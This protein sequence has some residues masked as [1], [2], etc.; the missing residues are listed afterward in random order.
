MST[1]MNIEEAKAYLQKASGGSSLYDHLSEVLLKIL[2]EKPEDSCAAF[3]H[4]SEAVKQARFTTVGSEDPDSQGSIH[5][6]AAQE[7]WCD[8]AL[9]LLKP[10]SEED[11]GP[12][13][14]GVSDLLD[15]SN[16]FEWAGIGFSR[17]ETFRLA[18]ALQNLATS[19][20]T[21][22]MRLWGKILGKDVDFYI[23]EGQCPEA[24]ESE[25]AAAYEGAE[26]CN[27]L[28]YWAMKDTGEYV[29]EK[30]PAVSRAQIQSA[31]TL[32]R[33][34]GGDLDA[35]VA[36]NPPFPGTERNFLRAQIARITASTAICP[37]GFFSVSD[38]G[39]VTVAE[40][41]EPKSA[42]ELVEPAS[43]V[44]LSKELNAIYGRSTPMPARE[45]EDG[46]MLPWE[47]EEFVEVLRVLTEDE[48][49]SWKCYNAPA[50]LATNTGEVAVLKSLV[51]PGAAAV[52]LGK[53]FLNVYVGDAVKFS[54]ESFQPQR[55]A[56]LQQQYGVAPSTDEN[57]TQED[58][59]P[60]VLCF[61]NLQEQP[62]VLE[63][64]TPPE[65]ADEEE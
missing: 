17:G 20:Q 22:S 45:G 51:W 54:L 16:L 60:A 49:G 55:P 47:G 48:Q 3:E 19:Q 62:D 32:K 64:P 40:E 1:S 13:A 18:V 23:A 2:V 9:Q 58:G 50:T 14:S 37:A 34:I 61:T 30:L 57:T 56:E 39:E 4:I 35:L 43:W 7:K 11:T 42:S 53:K 24:Y 41:I 52:G 29:W 27:K 36:G 65:E 15:E 46:E 10:L 12:V 8:A 5:V 63:D 44:H 21:S 38:E 28:S 26:G 31:R 59:A 25:D 33:Y 6:K